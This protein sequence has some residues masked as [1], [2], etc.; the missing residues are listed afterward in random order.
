M[1][2]ILFFF[3]SLGLLIPTE[4][5]SINVVSE[6]ATTK[7]TTTT[8]YLTRH[9]EKDRSDK[10]NRNPKLT[11]DGVE[12]ANNIA[13]MLSEVGI[14][15]VYATNYIRTMA[16]ATPTANLFNKEIIIYDWNQFDAEKMIQENLGKNVLIVGHSNTT[17]IVINKL[18]GVDTYAEIDDANFSNF[19]IVTI[20][21][22]ARSSILLKIN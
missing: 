10:S 3:L 16:T 14:D 4:T 15:A 6:D 20:T 13:R 11:D 2:H 18:L 21:S 1:N 7:T 17:P 12:R 22:Q 9:A 19:Y 5:T 8:F